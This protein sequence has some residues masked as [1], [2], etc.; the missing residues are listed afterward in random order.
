MIRYRESGYTDGEQFA[1]GD[2]TQYI[3]ARAGVGLTGSYFDDDRYDPYGYLGLQ[4]RVNASFGYS[5]TGGREIRSGLQWARTA[6]LVDTYCVTWQPYWDSVRDWKIGTPV[7]YQHVIESG[8]TD[9]ETVDQL[10]IGLRL[11]RTITEHL[12]ASLEYRYVYRD[13]NL[14]DR[15][16]DMHSVLLRFGYRF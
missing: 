16:Y 5:L 4:H 6:E 11:E 10:G 14:P 13:S 8:G 12:T 1:A 15:D 2:V 9:D 7:Y 3:N